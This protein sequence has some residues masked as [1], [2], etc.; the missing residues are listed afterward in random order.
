MAPLCFCVLR[1]STFFFPTFSQCCNV[2]AALPF[3][4]IS[5]SGCG[6]RSDSCNHPQRKRTALRKCP[7]L[8]FL[9]GAP[10]YVKSHCVCGIRQGNRN[11]I[12]LCLRFWKCAC[13][14]F[15]CFLQKRRQGRS[16][17]LICCRANANA[18]HTNRRYVNLL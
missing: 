18:A 2:S 16:F 6:Y 1:E 10:M 11:V 12:S 4:H 17:I 7:G 8:P 13:T 9:N 15:I 3:I 5:A 14:F